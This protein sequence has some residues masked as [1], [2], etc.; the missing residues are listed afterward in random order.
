MN[1]KFLSGETV[2]VIAPYAVTSGNGVLVGSYFGVAKHTAAISTQVETERLGCVTLPAVSANTFA[3]GALVYWDNVARNC[4]S[5]SASNRIIGTALV[6]KVGGTTTVQV[7]LD[8]A[9]R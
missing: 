1:N 4:T 6:A 8:G 3:Q 2:P 5:T 9:A 7:T